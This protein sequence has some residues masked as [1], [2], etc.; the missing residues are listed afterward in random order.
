MPVP[1]RA[2]RPLAA[3]LVACLLAACATTDLPPISAGG[4][5]FAPLA[6][7]VELWQESRAE[8]DVLLGVV[9]LYDDP[10]LDDYL[11]TVASRL[12]P[13]G[14]AANPALDVRVQVIADTDLNAFAY[15]HGAIYVHS[16]LLA[17]LDNEDQL[18]TVLG[19]EMSH[20]E[21]RHMLRH[22]RAAHNR[23]VA[24]SVAA[25]AAAVVIAGEEA[26]AWHD[27]DWGKAA[28]IDAVGELFVGVGL[29]LAF[30]AAVNGYGRDL[31]IEADR[32]GF[33]KLEA[34][35]YRAEEAP[36][37]YGSLLAAAG[38]E[39]G[40][41][42]TFF[43]GSHPRL[44][45]RIE[46]AQAWADGRSA[47]NGGPP[48]AAAPAEVPPAETLPA[49]APP[50]DDEFRRRVGPLVRENG[51]LHLEAGRLAEAERDLLRAAEWR[52]DDP[53]SHSEI[54]R[55]RLAQADAAADDDGRRALRAQAAQ[56][57]RE[58]IRLDAD[59]APAHRHL[60]LLLH[61][62]GDLAAA[63]RSLA[64]YL[65]LAPDAGDAPEVEELWSDLA[66]AGA[67]EGEP[68]SS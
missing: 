33:A 21:Y 30:L 57:F 2:S 28:A 32:G 51:V 50:G 37:M 66:A 6:D 5:D 55:L 49:E 17:R 19:H 42:A 25:V 22:R 24:L 20:V 65:E 29:Q 1:T 26:E 63:C 48:A 67:C 43:F 11:A 36:K 56:A 62:E 58:A 39:N 64:H 7:E 34:A 60:G 35:G 9:D 27:G 52:P 16:G 14:M 46:S 18:A 38:P 44:S 59:H 13:P 68:A 61:L 12:E 45:E 4:A 23:A 47:S 10:L 40:K 15:P 3:A 8:E 31:E 41:A 54:G 53:A